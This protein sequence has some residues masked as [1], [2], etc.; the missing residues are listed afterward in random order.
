AVPGA[1]RRSGGARATAEIAWPARPAQS[2]RILSLPRLVAMVAPP[3][4]TDRSRPNTSSVSLTLSPITCT[5]TLVDVRPAANVG[6]PV[7]DADPG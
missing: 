4:G 3:V 5:T 7:A 2:P 1:A 6:A